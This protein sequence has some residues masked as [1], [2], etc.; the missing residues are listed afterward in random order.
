N[1]PIPEREK[2]VNVSLVDSSDESGVKIISK[3]REDIRKRKASMVLN[4]IAGASELAA[5][6]AAL[7]P[8][9]HAKGQPMGI[10][11]SSGWGGQNIAHSLQGAA[12]ALNNTAS[13]LTQM[14]GIASTVSAYIRREQEWTHQANLVAKEIG[15]VE[16]QILSA[17][18][19]LQIAEKELENHK[20]Q[21]DNANTI[22]T[23]LKEKFTNKE[24][25][26]WMKDQLKSL[27]KQSFDLA[28]NMAK[29]AEKA[30]EFEKGPLNEGSE[31]IEHLYWDNS[32]YG[33]LAGE[34][35]QLA[36]RKMD[37]AFHEV[38]TRQFELTKHISLKQIN[39]IELIR[40]RET[41]TCGFSF[42]EE[43]FDLDYPGHYNRRIKSVSLSIPCVVGPYTTIPCTLRLS[44][45]Q[46]R[47]TPDLTDGALQERSIPL[48]VMA[49]SS[50][51][52]DS[53]VFELNFRD[54]R[55]VPF[56]GAGVL[57]TWNIEL[58]SNKEA[59]DF[60]KALRQF[61]YSTISDVIIHLRYT[62]EYDGELKNVALTHLNDYFEDTS[63]ESSPSFKI[64]DLKRD[65]PSEWHKFFH[66]D[67]VT[68]ENVMTLNISKDFFSYRDKS[69]DLHIKELT[70]IAESVETRTSYNATLIVP[71]VDPIEINL[72]S[73]VLGNL[74]SGSTT[75][76]PIVLDSSEET[77]WSL[78]INSDGENL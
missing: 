57:S 26:M 65:F 55:Y 24:L 48:S 3:E 47:V 67:E 5:S 12:K 8:T 30:F 41:G 63:G 75:D 29:M 15:Q 20:K 33:L 1:P 32:K 44:S 37:K 62:A 59:D 22:E 53:G 23:Y 61:D 10:G 17:G 77:R 49:T 43:L 31:Y 71:E 51:Q 9:I 54:E 4:H 66:A 50:A 68:N 42:T 76:I 70:I 18:I 11:I 73:G 52:Q 27:H 38:N 40:L 13:T 72:V 39:P 69:Q 36:I 78:R 56:E 2:N 58:F 34:K 16:R 74:L 46:V 7:F 64:F 35:L 21:I 45:S 60:G 25:Y 28:F 19:R 6:V 14:A